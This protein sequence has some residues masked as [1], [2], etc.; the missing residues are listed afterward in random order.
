MNR[1]HRD[2]VFV[3]DG[4]N[5]RTGSGLRHSFAVDSASGDGGIAIEQVRAR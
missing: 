4:P 5:V 2:Q 3:P 1:A